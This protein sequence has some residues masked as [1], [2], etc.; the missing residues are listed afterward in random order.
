MAFGVDAVS[1]PAAIIGPPDDLTGSHT[2]GASANLLLFLPGNGKTLA[3]VPEE[4]DV[5]SVTYNGVAASLVIREDASVGWSHQEIWKL[6]N[7]AIGAA[8]NWVIN[9]VED[10]ANRQ[11]ACVAVSFND[12]G[13]VKTPNSAEGTGA[14]GSVTV[15]DSANGDIVVSAIFSDV[16]PISVTTEGGT[17]LGED[18]NIASDSDYNAQRQ[19]AVGANTVCSWTH[20]AEKWAA[21][22]VAIPAISGAVMPRKLITKLQAINRGTF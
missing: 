1:H 2:C 8:H 9:H 13:V 10:A 11:V 5:A 14:N 6:V 17:L 19:N 3:S 4:R 18:E 22:G 12:A 15:A 20:S 21:C 7:P 16:G